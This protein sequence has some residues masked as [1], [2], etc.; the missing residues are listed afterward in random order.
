MVTRQGL[1][2]WSDSRAQ[3]QR[4]AGLGPLGNAHRLSARSNS[5]LRITDSLPFGQDRKLTMIVGDNKL[6]SMIV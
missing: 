3:E 1:E 2:I 6:G 5:K 4:L